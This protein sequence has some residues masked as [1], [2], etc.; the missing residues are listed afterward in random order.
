VSVGGAQGMWADD[1]DPLAWLDTNEGFA[2]RL[3]GSPQT[4]LQR[5]LEF[6]QIGVD[7][8]HLTLDDERFNQEVLPVLQTVE[9]DHLHLHR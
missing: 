6:H 1:E 3:I 7:C 8:F 5:M 9:H 4:I 2:S